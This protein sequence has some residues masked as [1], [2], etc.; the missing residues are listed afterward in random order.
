MCDIPNWVTTLVTITGWVVVHKLSVR[1]DRRNE[2]SRKKDAADSKLQSARTEFASAITPWLE[3][4]RKTSTPPAI[5]K[6][7]LPHIRQAVH[8]FMPARGDVERARLEA[9]WNK[10]GAIGEDQLQGVQTPPRP[11]ES[12]VRTAYTAAIALLV[13]PLEAMLSLPRPAP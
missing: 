11:G 12:G 5:R 8:R 7:S 1:R 2:R 4:I 3:D 9:E 10:Y 13:A 6:Q